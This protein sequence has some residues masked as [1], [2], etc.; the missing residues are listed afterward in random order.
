MTP[1]PTEYKAG[2][3]TNRRGF[4]PFG[5]ASRFGYHRANSPPTPT[6][7]HMGKS[8]VLVID[9]DPAI[10]ELVQIGL[11]AKGLEVDEAD[12]ATA[13][14]AKLE[15]GSYDLVLCDWILPDHNG[16]KLLAWAKQEPKMAGLPFVMVTAKGGKDFVVKA[17]RLGADGYLVKPFTIELLFHKVQGVIDQYRSQ[18][19]PAK[20]NWIA[21]LLRFRNYALKGLIT[22]LRREVL[23]LR[24]DRN[25]TLPFLF[26]QVSIDIAESG[27]LETSGLRGTVIALRAADGN[28]QADSVE[29]SLHLR[30]LTEQ[31]QQ[32]LGELAETLTDTRGK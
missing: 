13:G 15:A 3:V 26:E 7:A 20:E 2:P 16:D 23:S 10:L 12:T 22:E 17:I 8:K 31:Q 19:E 25:N 9:D 1:S 21:G 24:L 11:T 32:Q 5:A 28:P 4:L 27:R 29:L 6:T 14:K 30:G 18:R